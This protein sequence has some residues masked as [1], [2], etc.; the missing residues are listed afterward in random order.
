MEK[1][2]SY[3]ITTF[4]SKGVLVQCERALTAAKN[5]ALSIGIRA[6][7][8][9]VLASYKKAPSS[10]VD[11]EKVRKTFKVCEGIC[12]TYSGLSGDFRVVLETAREICIG[13]YKVYGRFPYVDTFMKEF[14]KVVQ[15]KTQ[16]GGLRPFGCMCL[17]GGYA[18]IRKEIR[19]KDEGEIEIVEVEEAVLQPLLFQ[20]DPS[21]SIKCC[22]TSG[23]GSEY[24]E[25]SKF[26]SKRCTPEI[27][28]HDAVVISALGVKEFTETPVTEDDVDICILTADGVKIYAKKEIEE[29]LKSLQ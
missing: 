11:K 18:P 7:N 5:G 21:G 6:S 22:F 9:V 20:I 12:G 14:S 15:E 17:F 8:G 26:L 4:S 13:Y 27:E 24:K 16:K 1:E 29:V 2:V 19:T 25:C 10:L 23:I 3:S 28:I